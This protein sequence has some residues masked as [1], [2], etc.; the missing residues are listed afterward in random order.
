MFEKLF[1]IACKT[2]VET[3]SEFVGEFGDLSIEDQNL[4]RQAIE[5]DVISDSFPPY[6]DMMKVL[7]STAHLT[8]PIGCELKRRWEAGTLFTLEGVRSA[9]VEFILLQKARNACSEK[10]I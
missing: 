9:Y 5:N 7:A 6:T 1:E 3:V 8:S 10:D 4:L 2:L